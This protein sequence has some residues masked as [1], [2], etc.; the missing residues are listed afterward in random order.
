LV[1]S[2][3]DLK[4]ALSQ[5]EETE[6]KYSFL[7]GKLEKFW[8]EILIGLSEEEIKN[9]L[10]GLVDEESQI[11]EPNVGTSERLKVSDNQ[12]QRFTCSSASS[13][14]DPRWKK[15]KC[16]HGVHGVH[17]VG[18]RFRASFCRR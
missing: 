17:G 5:V 14:R 1:L 2:I 11:K 9:E 4:G 6:Q 7:F 16:S 12:T 13:I 18:K 15:K 10:A 8:N 3:F